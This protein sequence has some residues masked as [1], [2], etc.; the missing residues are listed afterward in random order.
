MRPDRRGGEQ[1]QSYVSHPVSLAFAKP[2][3]DP[4]LSFLP[5]QK[6]R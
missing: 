4:F 2:K 1:E 3:K 6:A 5:G